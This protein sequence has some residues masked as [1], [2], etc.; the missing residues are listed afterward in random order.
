MLTA[1]QIEQ[2]LAKLKDIV[3]TMRDP[4]EPLG[5]KTVTIDGIE[6]T[7]FANV[8]QN[9][10]DIYR[11]GLSAAEKDFLVYENERYTF[12]QTLAIA[13]NIAQA[14]IGQYGI[15]KGDRVAVCSRNNPEWCMAYM[16]VT[17]IG[18]IVVP[19]NSWWQSSEL[20]YG[21][22]D[23][24]AKVLFADQERINQLVPVQDNI[25]VSII[26]IKPDV[27]TTD[28]PE[29]HALAQT[30]GKGPQVDLN[31]ITLAPEDDASIMYTSGSTGTPKGVLSTHRNIV[32][33]LYSWVFGKEATDTLRP[34]LVENDPEFDPGILSNVPLFHVTGSHAQFLVS[35]VYLRK[36]VMMYKWNAE[37]ALELIETERLSVLHGV[38]TMTW[39]VM[40][41]PMFDKTDLRSLRTVQSGGASRPPG[42]LSMMQKK[43][44]AIVQPG[45]G[46]GLTETNAIGATITGAFYLAKPEST[47]R[48]TQPVTQIR[49]EDPDGNVLEHGQ[50]GEI[51]IKGATVMKAYWQRP[52]ETADAIRNGWFHTGDIGLLDE[53]GFL[54]IKDRAKD[55]VIRG[56]ENVAC[57][58]VEYALSEH[59]DVFEAAV[60][61]L[62]DERLGEIVGATVMVK[63]G[64]KL[65]EADLQG[66]LREH[67]A[68][69][70][71]PSHIWFET[72]Q[73]E[74]IASGKIAK[75]IL[76][77]Q[78]IQR[79][80][81]A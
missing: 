39:E 63:P 25:N 5:V 13:E 17:M 19:M 76:R 7:V 27:G 33:A 42:H 40:H 60:Y 66:F 47:G 30:A 73:L 21:L 16:A 56:G 69:Y 49:I 1:Q 2:D 45:L 50:T 12:A 3:I 71:V 15:E 20:V 78:A 41:S 29:F 44:D 9:L 68:H 24:G 32:N 79:L 8:P 81:G 59:P 80:H 57:A 14:L 74:R 34:E 65:S 52:G 62:P 48:P 4:A 35:F 22:K 67:I 70:K 77:E 11:L 6:Q 18:G 43:F 38:P 72:E 37:K 54:V 58:E 36:F 23:S 64:A 75:K 31:G 61:G 55:I 26:A 28:F 46:Y 51:C 53:H 10:R